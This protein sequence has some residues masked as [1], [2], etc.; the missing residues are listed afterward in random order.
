MYVCTS[1]QLIDAKENIDV[2]T[3]SAF[4]AASMV[5]VLVPTVSGG[6]DV[7]FLMIYS[8]YIHK[9]SQPA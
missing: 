8:Q 6:L 9:A 1:Y 2:Y 4:P 7:L 5:E 3:L